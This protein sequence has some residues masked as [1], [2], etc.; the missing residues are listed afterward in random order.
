MFSI[1]SDCGVS[2][3]S[4]VPPFHSKA[5]LVT[6][7]TLP[8]PISSRQLFVS[9]KSEEIIEGVTVTSTALNLNTG[10]SAFT[11]L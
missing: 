1:I 5:C 3:I 7:T 4:A 8:R 6:G 2:E 9:E 10:K 11:P